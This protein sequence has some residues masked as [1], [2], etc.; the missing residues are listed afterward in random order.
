MTDATPIVTAAEVVRFWT[1]AGPDRWFTKDDAFDAEIRRRFLATHEAAAENK[2]RLGDDIRRAV[3]LAPH[4]AKTPGS[5]GGDY[6]PLIFRMAGV[7][8][9]EDGWAVLLS[10]RESSSTAVTYST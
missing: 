2:D 9:E 6:L 5:L 7:F 8:G 3:R 10:T 4:D 1:E